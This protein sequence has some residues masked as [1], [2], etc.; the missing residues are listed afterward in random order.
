[1]SL[2]DAVLATWE[3][4]RAQCGALLIEIRLRGEDSSTY[5]FSVKGRQVAQANLRNESVRKLR[6]LPDEFSVLL[7][8]DGEWPELPKEKSGAESVIGDLRFGLRDVSFKAHVTKKSEVR[9]VTTRD[10]TP[11]LVCQVT[12]SD[13]TGEIPLAIWNN[14]IPTI[15][16]GDLVQI[17]N[18]RVRSFRGQIQLALNRKTGILTV[19]KPANKQPINNPLTQPILV[20]NRS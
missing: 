13:G 3:N 5:M 6:R 11:L 19:L 14:Q 2:H 7:D 16:N 8:A 17:Q 1:V 15:S 10:G 4:G 20:A 12:L 18:A 9:A